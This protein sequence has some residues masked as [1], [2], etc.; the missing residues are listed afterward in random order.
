MYRSGL[1]IFPNE[2]YVS[3]ERSACFFLAHFFTW[4]APAS[5][6]APTNSQ[7]PYYLAPAGRPFCSV[8]LSVLKGDLK[9]RNRP[10]RCGCF[11]HCFIWTVNNS[12][13][14]ALKRQL[15]LSR[16]TYRYGDRRRNPFG[17]ETTSIPEQIHSVWRHPAFHIDSGGL[18][19]VPPTI[20]R[21]LIGRTGQ[22]WR[23]DCE[24][25]HSWRRTLKY[26][27]EAVWVERGQIRSSKR[28]TRKVLT[29]GNIRKDLK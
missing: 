14:A 2:Q 23:E 25:G 28:A 13:R 9:C 22:A 15:S 26:G 3:G 19:T 11:C 4:R 18:S 1:C 29:V 8:V 20:F 5:K 24:D 17:I 27:A 7:L 21:R 10:A 6:H 16:S 12:E